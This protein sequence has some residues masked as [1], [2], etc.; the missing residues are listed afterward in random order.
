M[1]STHAR[2]AATVLKD[3]SI[4]VGG[5]YSSGTTITSSC[6]I[7]KPSTNSWTTVKSMTTGR[8]NV[9]A[10]TLDDG[11]VMIA[12][13]ASPTAVATVEIYNP[14][15]DTWTTAA[16]MPTAKFGN[17]LVTLQSGDVLAVAGGS[18]T[19]TGGS[20]VFL[21]FPSNNTWTTA[22]PMPLTRYA[23]GT[24]MLNNGS[25]MTVG[26]RAA[27]GGTS[28]GTANLWT[29]PNSSSLEYRCVGAQ[30]HCEV[31]PKG[32]GVP[33]EECQK[34]CGPVDDLYDCISNRCVRAA[35]GVAKDV[36]ERICKPDSEFTD[37]SPFE[38]E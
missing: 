24:A 22:A 3:G 13:G 26:G 18:S 14:N 35:G 1:P 11:R 29:G 8:A 33:L 15:T 5:G 7:F 31:V 16:S 21:Y 36:C 4:F 20:S 30:A 25:V 19:W 37:T 28:Y 32:D 23:F 2:F 27:G 12:G 10:A 17:G 6:H 34:V 9:A 38:L